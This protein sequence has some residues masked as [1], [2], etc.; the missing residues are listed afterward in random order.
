MVVLPV[1][2]DSISLMQCFNFSIARLVE[3]AMPERV[4]IDNEKHDR[5]VTKYTSGEIWR[6][7]N[8]HHSDVRASH[9]KLNA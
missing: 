3:C 7:F 5:G 1:I 2:R 8:L 4:F 9:T 6:V